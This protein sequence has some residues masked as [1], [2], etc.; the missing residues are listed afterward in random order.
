M[1]KASPG[2]SRGSQ[3]ILEA[4]RRKGGGR[5]CSQSLS[6]PRAFDPCLPPAWL[7][8]QCSDYVMN[9]GARLPGFKAHIFLLVAAWPWASHLFPMTQFLICKM[10]MPVTISSSQKIKWLWTCKVLGTLW[11][12]YMLIIIISLFYPRNYPSGIGLHCPYLRYPQLYR[13]PQVPLILWHPVAG[14]G[15]DFFSSQSS[16]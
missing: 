14:W 10:G 3:A 6:S 7:R 13:V 15:E 9:S 1:N 5:R 4:C 16:S 12:Q 2:S 8:Q 11:Y